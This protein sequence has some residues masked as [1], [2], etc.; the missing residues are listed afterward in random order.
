MHSLTICFGP[1]ATPWILLFKEEVKAATIYNEY[2]NHLVAGAS[3][4][5]LIGADDFGQ[6][7]VLSI[8]EIKGM[9]LE[10]MDASQEAQIERGLHQA[11]TQAKAE[12]KAMS[13]ETIKSAIRAKQQGPAV[14]SP[15]MPGGGMRM[16]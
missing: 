16:S 3:S 4:G 13:D 6:A 9:M 14:Y 8:S 12:T 10:D 1:A 5:A 2:S 11:R 15:G 7:F